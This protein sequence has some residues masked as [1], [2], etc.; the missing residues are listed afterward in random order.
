MTASKQEPLILLHGYP[1]DHTLWFGV[2]AALGTG[3]RVKLPDLPGF[4]DE[5]VL[6]EPPSMEAYADFLVRMMDA[7]GIEKAI[8]AGMSMGGYVALA[9]AAK[10]PHRIAGLGMIS[11]QAAADTEEAR[12]G[13][14]AM[15]SRIEKDGFNVAAQ[16]LLPKMF[17]ESNQSN[18]DFTRTVF[19]GAQKAGVAGLTYAL[20]AM[21]S[22]PNRSEFLKKLPIPVAFAH[23]SED[24]IIP[25]AQARSVAESCQFPTFTEIKGTGHATPLEAPDAVAALL[26]RLILKVRQRQAEATVAA[27]PQA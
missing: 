13:R 24:K 14:A 23:G 15:V 3:I 6:Q 12:K 11:T 16:A 17:S 4:G 9:L 2:I 8:V 5:P 7:Q 27:Q 21:G 1:F 22:R 18:Q 20:H 26:A 25:I 19:E 10:Y